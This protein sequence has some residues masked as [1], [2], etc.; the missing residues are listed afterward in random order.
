M[1]SRSRNWNIR[2]RSDS[3]RCRANASASSVRSAAGRVR[4]ERRARDRCMYQLY[5]TMAGGVKPPAVDLCSERGADHR[6]DASHP[7]VAVQVERGK[8][9][10]IAHPLPAA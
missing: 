5:A 7:A 8:A 1:R 3:T 10:R 9:E 6:L 2:T 4:E